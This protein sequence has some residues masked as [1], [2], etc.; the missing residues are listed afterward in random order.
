MAKTANI[1]LATGT[2][3][4][5]AVGASNAMSFWAVTLLSLILSHMPG[6]TW[7]FTPVNLFTTAVHE[8]GHALVC[9]A[10]GGSVHGLT[11]VSDGSGHGGL[12]FCLG[13]APFL[14]TQAGYLGSAFFGCVL[15]YL[16]QFPRVAKVLLGAMG[17][18]MTF[19]TIFFVT[20]ALAVPGH[21][22]QGLA[23]LA[24][25]ALMSGFLIWASVKLPQGPANLLVLFLAV[26]TALNS[27]TLIGDLIA[28]SCGLVSYGGFSDASNMAD[29]TMIPA[30]VWSIFWGA[31][32]LAMVAFTLW[33]TYGKRLVPLPAKAQSKM[34]S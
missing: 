20:G 32:S 1:S 17:L 29:L 15:I 33:S 19:A 23:S 28:I 2:K 34:K 6:L 24:S 7:L 9:V 25:A 10:T 26:Q 21:F 27:L 14:Y 22:L 16:S 30:P 8:M 11:I 5:A 31:L 3:D 4:S 12:T 13:G 18:A